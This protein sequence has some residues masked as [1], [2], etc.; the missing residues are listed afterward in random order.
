MSENKTYSYKDSGNVQHTIELKETSFNFADKKENSFDQKLKTKPTTFLKDAFKRFC[1]NK[2]SV[3]GAIVLGTLLILSFV[4]PVAITNDT[5]TT[6]PEASYLEPKLFS[7]GTGFWDGTRKISSAVCSTTEVT[8]ESN[9][10]S[11]YKNTIGYYYPEGYSYRSVM[12]L[13]EPKESYVNYTGTNV[14]GGYLRITNNLEYIEDE[15]TGEVSSETYSRYSSYAIS[16]NNG[17]SY[18]LNLKLYPTDDEDS[19][20]N[21]EYAIAIK[22]TKD[23]DTEE[24]YLT[25]FS[26]VEEEVELNLD[27]NDIVSEKGYSFSNYDSASFEIIVKPNESQNASLFVSSLELTSSDATDDIK[28]ELSEISF[29]NGN[30][31]L[32][33]TATTTELNESLN[34]YETK[35][36]IGYWTSTNGQFQLYKGVALT[37]SFTL[38]T[39][40]NKLGVKDNFEIGLENIAAYAGYSVN[41]NTGAVYKD[42]NSD[43]YK[44]RSIN[45]I[46]DD[47]QLYEGNEEAIIDSFSVYNE[48]KSPIISITGVSIKENAIVGT[49]VQFSC[50]I[51]YY[52]YLGLGDS[53]PLYLFGT[54]K[55]GKDLLKITFSG[56]RTSL[57]LGIFTFVVCFSFG[58]VLGSIEGYYGGWVDIIIQRLTEILSGIPWIVVMTL[59]I[60][61]LGSNFWTF[62][63]ALCMTGW[64]ATSNRARTQFYRF[65]GREYI[66]ASRTLGASDVRLIFKHILPNSMGTIITSSVLMIPSVIFSEATISYLGLGLKNIDSLGVILSDNQPNLSTYPYSLIL[67]AVVIAL[68]MI[69]FNLFGNGLRDAFN[70]TLKGEE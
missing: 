2:S 51:Y 47:D 70:P 5:T 23:G 27:I 59:V 46:L 48:K 58:L 69:S 63:L 30:E 6:H 44:N 57:L 11:N 21:G 31:V 53:M 33:R 60:L 1:K 55:S 49:I 12:N 10:E 16:L 14:R 67:P 8:E 13:S 50:K 29:E 45:L 66:L 40:E 38:D 15:E 65:K 41:S 32:L 36:N 3:V 4:L 64:I 42:T 68:I 37:C 34:Q 54:D 18:N 26:I 22:Y 56:L 28:E 24:D 9:S 43:V 19:Y 39:Y 61:A 7:A 20:I 35:D 52:R 62:A 25:D 17:Y